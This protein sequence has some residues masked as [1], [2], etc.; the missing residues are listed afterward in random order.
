MLDTRHERGPVWLVE[1]ILQQDR[2]VV[3]LPAFQGDHKADGPGQRVYG[4]RVRDLGRQRSACRRGRDPFSRNDRHEEEFVRNGDLH[5]PG[6]GTDG[7]DPTEDACARVVGVP[8]DLARS[9]QQLV[10]RPPVRTECVGRNQPGA[11]R[12]RRR[13][14]PP[15]ER[16][17][18]VALD[19]VAVERVQALG[20]G[21]ANQVVGTLGDL[22]CALT[23]NVDLKRP[24]PPGDDDFVGQVQ[25]ER[26][27][28]ES[29]S[30]VGRRGRR[31]DAK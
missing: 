17:A 9:P 21:Q 27:R 25:G 31:D 24:R 15:P 8:L 14:Q 2:Q 6:A 1:T 23:R 16:N 13:A 20:H 3:E 10:G 30:E 19:D 18:V 29:R 11:C 12:R 22:A 5:C 4:V 26:Q 28:I 7:D